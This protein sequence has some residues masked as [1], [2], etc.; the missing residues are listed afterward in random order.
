MDFRRAF[1]LVLACAVAIVAAPVFLVPVAAQEEE[2]L[3]KELTAMR[4]AYD[5]ARERLDELDFQ[6][7]V[8]E[9][10]SVIDP[11]AKTRPSD[12]GFEE[13]RL[14]AA[15]YDLRARAQFNLG[16]AAAAEADFTSLLRVDPSYAI[17]RQTLSPKV[18]DLF[19]RVRTRTVGILDLKV[20]PPRARVRI[21]GDPVE[22]GPEGIG[23]LSG[24]HELRIEMDGYEPHIETITA[25]GGTRLDRNVRLRANK[26]AL[27]FITVPAGVT[28]TVDDTAKGTT[29]GPA[30]P[31]VEGLAATYGFDAK[32]ASGPLQVPLVTPGEH[33]VRFDRDCYES[34]SVVVRV[35][36]DEENRPLRFAPVV[37]K[38]SRTRLQ[39]TSV[40]SGA[41]VQVDGQKQ[42]TTP[43]TLAS[44][45]GG[46]REITVL[47]DGVGRW[48]ERVRLATGQVNTLDVRLRPTLLYVGTFRLDEWGRAV[49][50]DEDKALLDALGR[51]LKTLNV[52]RVPSVQQ[53]IRDAV[54][55]WMI[56]DPR[57]ARGGTL[58]PPDILKDAADRAGADL[59]L[60]GLTLSDDPE[61]V[62]TLGL[63]SPLH[64]T[65]DIVRL[66]LDKPE[67]VADF[68]A[69]LD[70]APAE[71]ATLWGLGLADTTLPPGGPVVA[72]VLAGSPAAKAGV[73]V[74]DRLTGVGSR[75]V[76][77]TREAL[78][79]L[80]SE[81][82]RAGGV[83]SAVVL[84][85]Q[86]SE[87]ARTTRITPAEAPALLSLTDPSLLYNRA[88][89][90]YRLR[91]RAAA[92]ETARG[93]AALNT[94]LALMH[95]RAY[96]KALAEGLQRASLPPGSGI[97]AGTVDYYRGL[98][99][100]RRGD[101]DGAR[102]AWQAASRAAGS[103]LESPDGPSAAAAASRALQSLQ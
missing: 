65:A 80:E 43:L 25:A 18:V 46:D 15:A 36:L 49:W 82:A 39:I 48:S 40:P 19:D 28:V 29:A 87:G 90:E 97:S 47:R 51:G 62:W 16:N 11:R 58:L 74:G 64:A 72:R 14:L 77:T 54:V 91:T 23:V 44:L 42:G 63:Y 85:L 38:E 76:T 10:G 2:D 53:S 96:D 37:L 17:D 6:G 8:K 26:R 34:Q 55:R 13:S 88:L 21:D 95:F 73:R 69:R 66:R 60:A 7:A 71:D 31:E 83:R 101:A 98:C 75:K 3:T 102:A 89:A 9:L 57:E 52:A 94:G 20:D 32:Q 67:G 22:T 35:D 78:A 84:A 41:E 1:L 81:S 99:A 45:C 68:V 93:V 86:S 5:R 27:E 12:L 59:V 61:H 92:D 30:T 33:K 70:S 79:T 100:Q 24:T 56:A 4:A 50:S 103:T